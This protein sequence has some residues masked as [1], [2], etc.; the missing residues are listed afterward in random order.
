MTARIVTFLTGPELSRS[1][2]S[3]ETQIATVSEEGFFRQHVEPFLTETE[4]SLQL[5]TDVAVNVDRGSDTRWPKVEFLTKEGGGV[6]ALLYP[7]AT[8]EHT[9]WVLQQ[10]W[11]AGLSSPEKHQVPEP[12]D[13]LA[14]LNVVL[15]RSYLDQPL[16]PFIL[17]GGK[18][19]EAAVRE[20]ARWLLRLHS[21]SVR[22]GE[23]LA[24]DPWRMF[25]ELSHGLSAAA[26]RYPQEIPQL[27]WMLGRVR[28]LAKYRKN[29]P[30]VQ[31]HG[32]FQPEN[33][34]RSRDNLVA[35]GFEGSLPADPSHDLATFVHWLQIK[36]RDGDSTG[37]FADKLSR[38]FLDE[39]RT[40]QP[41]R[42][43]NLA[44]YWC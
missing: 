7:E 37:E 30:A 10:L 13:W 35:T 40:Q 3:R 12:L 29:V 34:F 38:A 36:A 21:A 9:Y 32:Q 42:S 31:G 16:A 4:C 27:T 5:G 15:T 28:A 19:A 24:H 18:E 23:Q 2:Y 33:L 39:Y 43:G 6:I 44:Y 41:L 20:A 26:A 25:F 22:V 14:D 11:D 1:A 17:Q 8:T